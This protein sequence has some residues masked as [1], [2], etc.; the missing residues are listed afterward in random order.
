VEVTM[1]ALWMAA[2]IVALGG[3]GLAG[4]GDKPA[5]PKPAVP[6]EKKDPKPAAAAPK[7]PVALTRPAPRDFDE[8]MRRLAHVKVSVKFTDAPVGDVVDYIRRV[9]GFNVIVSPVLQQKGLDAIKPLTMSLNEVSLKQVSELVGQLTSMKFKFADGMLQL[10]TPEDAR[11]KPVLRII[12]IGDLT[13][14]IHNFPG[15]ELD[16]RPSKSEATPDPET[17]VEN[18]WSDP[19]KVIDLIQKMCAPET[20]GDADVSISADANKLI[21]RQY[22]EVQKEIQRLVMMLRGAR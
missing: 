13:M 1:R 7:P 15:P 19:Q 8:A 2:V 11:G 5:S 18:A 9:A 17:D 10:T 3:T 6:A 16:L 12:S 22:P 21:V 4:D 14:P 20:W